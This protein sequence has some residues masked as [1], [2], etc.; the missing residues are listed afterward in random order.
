MNSVT[1]EKYLK[2][3]LIVFGVIFLLIYPIGLI[4]PSGWTWYGGE[5][6]YYLQM[7]CGIYAVLGIFLIA[8]AKNPSQNQSLIAFTIWSSLVHAVIMAPQAV[9][10]GHELGHLIGDVPALLLVAFVLWFL[11]PRK[12]AGVSTV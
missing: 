3:A 7:I 11:S 1:R 5:G 8:A 6:A 2:I 4:W 10:D 12:E 9:L